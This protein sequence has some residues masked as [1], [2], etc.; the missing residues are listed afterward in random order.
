MYGLDVYPDIQKLPFSVYA[1]QFILFT[2][3]YIIYILLI[4]YELYVVHI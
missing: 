4:I 1:E 3:I 2:I